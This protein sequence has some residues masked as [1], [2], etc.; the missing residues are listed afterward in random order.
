QLIVFSSQFSKSSARY[1]RIL[2]LE[3]TRSNKVPFLWNQIKPPAI[4]PKPILNS[5][6]NLTLISKN[7]TRKRSP[8]FLIFLLLVS[9]TSKARIQKLQAENTFLKTTI[10][11]LFFSLSHL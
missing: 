10:S 9:T 11:G 6:L 1:F 4:N 7:S 5:E 3:T 8:I 2:Y